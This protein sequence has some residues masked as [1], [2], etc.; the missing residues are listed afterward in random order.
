MKKKPSPAFREDIVYDDD[1]GGSRFRRRPADD[2]GDDEAEASPRLALPARTA[3]EIEDRKAAGDR[4][5]P[6]APGQARNLA[7]SFWGQA[8][9]RYLMECADYASR[10]PRGRSLLRNGRVLGFQ[11]TTGSLRA[12]VAGLRLYDVAIT[13]QPLDD[14]AAAALA[15]RLRGHIGSVV[16]LLA[17]K[18]NDDVMRMVA[19]PLHG[20]FPAPSDIRFHCSCPDDASLC[21]HAAATLYAAGCHFDEQPADLFRLRGLQPDALVSSGLSDVIAGLT[22]ATNP[23]GDTLDPASLGD[24]FGI[25]LDSPPRDPR[26]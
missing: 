21:E 2:G 18:L 9:N 15:A 13:V 10:L 7:T 22:T 16:D 4:L 12:S 20:L 5:D 24:L 26:P 17:G 3:R 14:D 1:G 6:I 11:L 8:W 23:T 25:Q 19:D